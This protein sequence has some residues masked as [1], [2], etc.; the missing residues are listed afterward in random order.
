MMVHQLEFSVDPHFWAF[1][2]LNYI[3]LNLC[4]YLYLLKKKS[5]FNANDAFKIVLLV[6]EIFQY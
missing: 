2:I 3:Y 6:Y 4:I 1:E 5:F